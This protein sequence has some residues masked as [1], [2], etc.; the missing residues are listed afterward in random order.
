[1]SRMGRVLPFTPRKPQSKGS[2]ARPAAVQAPSTDKTAPRNTG[3]TADEWLE[4]M[5][6]RT[7]D[8]SFAELSPEAQRRVRNALVMAFERQANKG[9]TK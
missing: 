4:L 2:I 1:M 7:E 8:R 5:A 6:L 9:G 3:L